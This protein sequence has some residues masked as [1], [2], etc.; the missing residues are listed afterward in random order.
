[1]ADYLD[2]DKMKKFKFGKK[3]REDQRKINRGEESPVSF[4]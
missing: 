4:H 3:D 2:K 1:M